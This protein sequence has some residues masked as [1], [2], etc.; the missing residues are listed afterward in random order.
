MEVSQQPIADQRRATVAKNLL[1][2]PWLEEIK[3]QVAETLRATT[4]KDNDQDS[5]ENIDTDEETT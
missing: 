3:A 4:A 2:K 1:S 5:E